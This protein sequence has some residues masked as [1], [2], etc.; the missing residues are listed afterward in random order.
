MV[1]KLAQRISLIRIRKVIGL[2]VRLVPV[3]LKMSGIG[4][5]SLGA[6]RSQARLPDVEGLDFKVAVRVG[7]L[8]TAAPNRKKH[9]GLAFLALR[10]TAN[11]DIDCQRVGLP[12]VYS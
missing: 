4:R 9:S 1:G 10:E 7:T 12:E 5:L 11:V 3:F 6:W 2:V 8:P